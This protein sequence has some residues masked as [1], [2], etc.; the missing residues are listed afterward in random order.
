MWRRL[1]LPTRID[2]WPLTSLQYRMV[3]SGGLLIQHARY[4]WLLLA[5][6]RLIRRLLDSM[7]RKSAALPSQA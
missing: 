3:K 2:G 6:S 4:S 1:A 7:L 5:E